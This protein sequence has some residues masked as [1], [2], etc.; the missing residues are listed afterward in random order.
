M[1]FVEIRIYFLLPYQ[2]KNVC[3]ANFFKSMIHL[4]EGFS[5]VFSVLRITY[6]KT[7][8]DAFE[9]SCP[10]SKKE[11]YVLRAERIVRFR[12]RVVAAGIGALQIPG[13]VLWMDQVGKPYT[14]DFSPLFPYNKD[15]AGEQNAF[16]VLSK[17]LNVNDGQI[18]AVPINDEAAAAIWI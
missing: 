14:I 5:S 2:F 1:I 11:R 8:S 17:V 7:S 9:Y 18:A 3:F 6:S 10:C 16:Y 15:S 13:D 4:S 12:R